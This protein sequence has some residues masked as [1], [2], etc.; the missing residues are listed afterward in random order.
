MIGKCKSCGFW[1]LCAVS[2]ARDGAKIGE[3]RRH[4]PNLVLNEEGRRFACFPRTREDGWC[5]D[6]LPVGEV[7]A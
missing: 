4:A 7:A 2:Y 6:H 3:C 5:G 1:A